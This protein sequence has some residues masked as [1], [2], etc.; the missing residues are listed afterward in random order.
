MKVFFVTM[1]PQKN[2]SCIKISVKKT[3]TAKNQKLKINR[4]LHISPTEQA[5]S[6]L[7]QISHND[8]EFNI[9]VKA[10]C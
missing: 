9:E 10:L 6:T 8:K 1:K 4:V 3:F 5:S 2:P 7:I